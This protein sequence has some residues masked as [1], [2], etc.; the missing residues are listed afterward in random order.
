LNCLAP[1]PFRIYRS[2]EGRRDRAN[3]DNHRQ[4][5]PKTFRSIHP[6]KHCISPAGWSHTEACRPTRSSGGSRV[7]AWRL[8]ANP[9]ERGKRSLGRHDFLQRTSG[10][11][12]RLSE[13][14][15]TLKVVTACG[16]QRL[17]I[18]ALPGSRERFQIALIMGAVVELLDSTQMDWRQLGYRHRSGGTVRRRVKSLCRMGIVFPGN[19]GLAR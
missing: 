2:N 19:C 5:Q 18:N 10:Q 14:R 11:T 17:Q 1:R 6:R 7:G 15:L 3:A 4:K 9:D 13:G 8:S 12:K 16:L